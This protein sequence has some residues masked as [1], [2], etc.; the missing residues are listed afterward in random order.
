M[1]LI[2]THHVF[3]RPTVTGISVAAD[4]RHFSAFLISSTGPVI[5]HARSI[6]R[7]VV[8]KLDPSEMSSTGIMT[9]YGIW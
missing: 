3:M 6:L 8:R 4:T 9:D 5:P 1:C 7:L 2:T